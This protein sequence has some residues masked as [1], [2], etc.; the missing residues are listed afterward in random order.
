[1]WSLSFLSLSYWIKASPSKS[2]FNP[3]KEEKRKEQTKKRPR[4]NE[5]RR[6]QRVHEK[7][8]IWN[9]NGFKYE[10]FQNLLS[11]LPWK[12][13]ST[14]SHFL[15]LWAKDSVKDLMN[16]NKSQGI[17]WDIYIWSKKKMLFL[18]IFLQAKCLA[19]L[20]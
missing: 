7:K 1:M 9:F 4:E 3:T 14:L 12:L 8:R 11:K 5:K 17:G 19:N 13:L 2:N 10:L 15:Q 6:D 20:L 18:I 16:H